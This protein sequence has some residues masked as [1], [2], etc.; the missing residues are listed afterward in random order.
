MITGN[1]IVQ[2]GNLSIQP[3]SSTKIGTPTVFGNVLV[4][5]NVTLSKAA[6]VY[7][8]VFA[9]GKITMNQGQVTADSAT[10]IWGAAYAGDKIN[11]SDYSTISYNASY[12]S[13]KTTNVVADE[14]A[15]YAKVPGSWTDN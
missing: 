10:V 12:A 2:N 7:G 1:I 14:N 5:G 3:I 6:K 15:G 9:N 8:L 11:T 4:N 13:I